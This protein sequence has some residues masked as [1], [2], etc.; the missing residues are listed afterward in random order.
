MTRSARTPRASRAK[1]KAESSTIKTAARK[2]TRQRAKDAIPENPAD[3]PMPAAPSARPD[4]KLAILE[5]LLRRETGMTI[6]DACEATGWQAHSVRGAIA[7][8]LKKRGLH[9]V[10][11]KTGGMRTYHIASTVP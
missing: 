5:A 9:V 1:T 11:E 7:G 3:Q 10:S 8:A 6:H 2:N 4:S